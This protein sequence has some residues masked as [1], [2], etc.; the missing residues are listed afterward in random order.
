LDGR[1]REKV[2]KGAVSYADGMLYFREEKT[3]TMILVAAL[4]SGYSEKGRFEQTDRSS[5]MAWPHPVIAG[6]KLYL[7]D[8]DRLLCYDVKGD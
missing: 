8:Q 4:P 1:E 7:R 2:K 6:G 3:G 5:E